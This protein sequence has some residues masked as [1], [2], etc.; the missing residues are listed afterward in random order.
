MAGFLLPL[1]EFADIREFHL[2][3]SHWSCCF[4][5]PPGLSG[6]VSVDLRPGSPGLPNT[7]DPIVVTGTFHVREQ[8]EAGYVVAIYAMDD[9]TATVL[10]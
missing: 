7:V 9:A 4:G 3:G 8:K 6:W 5:V 1:Y 10:R 2:V